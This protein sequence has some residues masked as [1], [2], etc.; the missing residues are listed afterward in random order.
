MKNV[1]DDVKVDEYCY[2]QI[3]LK[4]GEKVI[5][6][7][8]KQVTQD[9]DFICVISEEETCNIFNKDVIAHISLTEKI[10]F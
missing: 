8:P 1:F 5:L 10:P 4:N 3:F 9:N 7:T 6:E 2:L